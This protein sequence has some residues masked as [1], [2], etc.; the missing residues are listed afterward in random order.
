MQENVY[1]IDEYG[2]VQDKQEFL[3]W[4]FTKKGLSHREYYNDPKNNDHYIYYDDKQ[5][6]EKWMSLGYNPEYGEFFNDDLRFS[7]CQNF[8]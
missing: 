6:M 8:S 4:A 3:D 5:T 2:E 1:I 7:T